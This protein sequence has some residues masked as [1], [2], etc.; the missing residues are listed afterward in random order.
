[1][2]SPAG[3]P[4]QPGGGCQSITTGQVYADGE[5]LG[6]FLPDTSV[7]GCGKPRNKPGWH[8]PAGCFSAVRNGTALA[9]NFG[10]ASNSSGLLPAEIEVTVR[11][12]V[13]APHLR[14]LGH[15]VVQGFII[16]H[17]ANQWIANFWL[18]ANAQWPQLDDPQQHNS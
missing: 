18:P 4:I 15:I 13:F 16:E 8:T 12:R 11:S 1:V 10:T 5:R 7:K 17:G 2:S 6:E 3:D 9:A 14:G